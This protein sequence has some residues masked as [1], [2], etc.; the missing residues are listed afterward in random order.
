MGRGVLC[1]RGQPVRVLHARHHH[2]SGRYR[3]GAGRNR[4]RRSVAVAVTVDDG[5]PGASRPSLSVHRLADHRRGLGSFP[6]PCAFGA[7][8]TEPRSR[9]SRSPS[10]G[11]GRS[12]SD[13]RPRCRPR[14][15]R[16]RGRHR[17][18]RRTGGRTLGRRFLGCGG[19]GGRGPSPGRQGSGSTNNSCPPVAPRG[20]VG[21]LGCCAS[22]HL[23]R[24]GLSRNRCL[25]VCPRRRTVHDGGQWGGVWG[26]G[27]PRRCRSPG[28]GGRGSKVG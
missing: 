23:G 28:G 27:P 12:R 11:G 22:H 5:E 13:G 7:H 8:R 14:S 21:R 25:L 24:S 15:W 18:G 20:A 10:G 6:W 4:H 26:Q 16:F 3:P 2:A 19:I 1:H 17:S 9:R